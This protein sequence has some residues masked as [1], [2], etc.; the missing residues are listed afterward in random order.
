MMRSMSSRRDS[1]ARLDRMF[2][3]GMS[4]AVGAIVLVGFAP[5]Y[6]LRSRF[7]DEPL[8]SHLHLHGVLFSAWC[9]LLVVQATL[10]ASRRVQWHRALGWAGAV[11]AVLVIAASTTAGIQ[12]AR[13]VAAA[14][15][16]EE[17][18]SFLTIPLFSMIVFS[19]LVVA[20]VA[21]RARPQTHKRLMLLATISVLDAP[22]AR[23]PGAPGA[24]GVAMLVGLLIVAA[25]AYDL[26]S[27]RRVHPVYVWGGALVVGN[28]LL[29]DVVGRTEAWHALARVLIG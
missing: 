22:I 6:F 7:T 10:V 18:R 28:Q 14:G 15:L 23:W 16:E 5:T 25:A 2:Y 24:T 21:W 26:A 13:R 27:R 19:G 1:H 29:R 17:A 4:I 9:A 12:T 20:A 8:P 11:L 3:L